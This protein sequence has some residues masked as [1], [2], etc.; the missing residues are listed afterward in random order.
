MFTKRQKEILSFLAHSKD[1]IP[2]E[3]MAKQLGISDR[4]VRHDGGEKNLSV[5]KYGCFKS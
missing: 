4:T 5:K 3:W 1:L 2:D